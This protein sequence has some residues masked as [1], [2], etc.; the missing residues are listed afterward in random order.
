[1]GGNVSAF[2]IFLGCNE[3]YLS[4]RT[5][6]VLTSALLPCISQRHKQYS[7]REITT[8]VLHFFHPL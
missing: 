5:A 7:L 1:M 3:V 4:D 6:K 8:F 2:K